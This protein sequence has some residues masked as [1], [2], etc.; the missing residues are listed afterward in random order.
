[1]RSGQRSVTGVMYVVA[2]VGRRQADD[3][4]RP[5]ENDISRSEG[6]RED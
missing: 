2:I 6:C 3:N 5:V 1:M 4:S